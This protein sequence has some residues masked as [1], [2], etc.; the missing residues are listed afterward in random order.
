M[1][2]RLPATVLSLVL[3]STCR[4]PA[5]PQEET[6]SPTLAAPISAVTP[7]MTVTLPE[8]TKPSPPP[9]PSVPLPGNGLAQHDFLY[10]GEW[11]TRKPMQTMFLVKGGKVVWS[12]EI[13]IKDQN[14][15]LSEYS[16]MHM[17]SNG[18]IVFAYKP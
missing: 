7:P 13:P 6:G 9:E 10:S 12:Y 4:I 8:E 3:L 16:D 18:D 17:L 1:N 5:A 2:P 11:D 15:N 14:N